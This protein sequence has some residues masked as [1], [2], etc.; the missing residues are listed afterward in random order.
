M[1]PSEMARLKKQDP[2]AGKPPQTFRGIP[3]VSPHPSTTPQAFAFHVELAHGEAN[4]QDY[5]A[6]LALIDHYRDGDNLKCPRCP[7]TTQ[8]VED[9][10]SHITEEM[11]TA[12]AGHG[13]RPALENQP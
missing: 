2:E 4:P 7:Y 3:L 12:M 13:A 8:S 5:N 9:F 6:T 10:I 1:K 11:N